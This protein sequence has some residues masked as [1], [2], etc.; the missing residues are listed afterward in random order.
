M[1]RR[2][3][4]EAELALP[5]LE[6]IETAL[7]LAERGLASAALE[8]LNPAMSADESRAARYY[9]GTAIREARESIP[10]RRPRQRS[11][12]PVEKASA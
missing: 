9:L 5:A 8:V 6:R 3:K 1:G 2:K 7:I 10:P 12:K 11:L 4:S